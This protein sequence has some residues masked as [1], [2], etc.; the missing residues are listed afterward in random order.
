MTVSTCHGRVS[1]SEQQEWL[2]FYDLNELVYFPLYGITN[3]VCRCSAGAGCGQNAG[4]H[5]IK[6]WKDRASQKPGPLDNIGIS[7]NNLVVV[8][9]DGDPGEAVLDEYPRTFTV[10]TGHGFHLWYKADPTKAVKS[11]AGWKHKVDIRGAGGMVVAPPSRHR[12]GS[13]YRHVR[14]DS[15]QPVPR[16]L[17]DSLP[18]RGERVRR[19]GHTVTP[20]EAT[21]P[22]VMAPLGVR[23]VE[24]MENWDVS[25]NQTL[26]R[27]ACRYFEFADAKLLGTDVLA[28]LFAAAVRT[29][30]TPDEVERTL[31][32]ASTS[33]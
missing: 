10:S 9:F 11:H 17:L 18:E 5:P 8:D 29:G 26:F 32:S 7:T 2:N 1:V 27:L 28:D 19:I 15:I 20:T 4:K 13:T 31:Q 22:D 12:S 25:R 16:W 23:L 14:G 24:Q 33:V 3:G 21:T 6:K 30:L